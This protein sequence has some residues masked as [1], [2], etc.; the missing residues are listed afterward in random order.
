MAESYSLPEQYEEMSLGELYDE[1]RRMEQLLRLLKEKVEVSESRTSCSDTP[2]I[3]IC[4]TQM[5]D[6]HTLPCRAEARVWEKPGW[7]R[8]LKIQEYKRYGR[9]MIM[10]EVGLS[11]MLESS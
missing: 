9:Q 10:P 3:D 2:D 5:L 6:R 7:T 8:S 4:S 1:I 11:G